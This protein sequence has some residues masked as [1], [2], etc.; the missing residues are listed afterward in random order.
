MNYPK[1]SIVV[2]AYNEAR[3]LPSCLDALMQLEY[4]RERLEIIVVDNNSTDKTGEIVKRYPVQY[5][6]EAKQGR[7]TARNSGIRASSGT[8]VA[9]IDADCI[10][11]PHWLK[12]IAG[13]FTGGATAGC[14]GIIASHKLD[15]PLEKYMDRVLCVQNSAISGEVLFL[16]FIIT[17]NSIFRKDALEKVNMFDEAL[18][19]IDDI[20]ISWRLL[21]QGYR[22]NFIPD[23]IVW[24]RHRANLAGF[25]E[26][27]FR[28]GAI[29]A[30]MVKRYSQILGI[31]RLL[32][33]VFPR[34]PSI[35]LSALFTLFFVKLPYYAGEI[36][37]RRFFH[38][39]D[40]KNLI[41]LKN[42]DRVIYWRRGDFTNIF[43]AKTAAFYSLD[44]AGAR[45]FELLMEGKNEMDIVNTIADEFDADAKDIKEDFLKLVEDLRQ[46]GILQ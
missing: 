18:S 31:T 10:A 12:R 20:D 45:A 36:Y 38:S 2:I 7:A 19:F 11:H 33:P 35:P 41:P 9:F 43:N 22:F 27:I 17:C 29:Q 46:N 28:Y 25:C 26:R 40:K 39:V 6:F 15:T 13:G 37:G 34:V 32:K 16:P 24:H 8:L 14:G 21:F 1:V 23:A 30:F 44:G 3:M 5:I 4:P 42:T